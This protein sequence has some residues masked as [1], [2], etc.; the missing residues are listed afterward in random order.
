MAYM[1][2][3]FN[4][5]TKK[6]AISKRKATLKAKYFTNKRHV[7]TSQG[8]VQLQN[9]NISNLLSIQETNDIEMES[10]APFS[11]RSEN[12]P[13]PDHHSVGHNDSFDISLDSDDNLVQQLREW[14]IQSDLQR[15]FL[16][17]LLQILKP[18]H[19]ELPGGYQALLETPR[20]IPVTYFFS[21]AISKP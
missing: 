15:H 11:P 21:Q 10:T 3:I 9:E 2:N 4:L 19:P 20:N 17:Q 5:S 1:C 12:I 8:N 7:N 18:Y 6:S 14:A 13:L 16:T